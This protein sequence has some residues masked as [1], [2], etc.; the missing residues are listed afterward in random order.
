[1][2]DELALMNGISPYEGLLP[3]Q[4]L[5]VP[6]LNTSGQQVITHVVQPGESV[7]SIAALYGVDAQTLAT[8]NGVTADNPLYVSQI[9][10]ITVTSADVG[11]PPVAPPAAEPQAPTVPEAPRGVYHTVVPGDTLFKIATQYGSTVDELAAANRIT[12]P[13]L[14]Y[15]G[16][17][18]LIP[19]LEPPQ[20]ASVLPAPVAWLTAD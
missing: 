8:A 20:I 10:T 14:I 12:D 19:G 2:P 6:V 1:S 16:Q 5:L 13:T 17:Q 18:L 15:A 4:T 9:L 3:G 11:Q 7:Q